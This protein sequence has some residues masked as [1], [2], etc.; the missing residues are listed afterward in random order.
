MMFSFARTL[1]PV[2]MAGAALTLQ[3]PSASAQSAQEGTLSGLTLFPAQGPAAEGK[4]LR[5]VSGSI[6]Q[7]RLEGEHNL[8]SFHV[9]VPKGDALK[10]RGLQ[11]EALSAI[12]ILPDLSALEIYVN[13]RLVGRMPID[14]SGGEALQTF[15]L[16]AGLL[17]EGYNSVTFAARHR[18]RVDC[19]VPATWELWTAVNPAN[20]GFVYTSGYVPG[21]PVPLGELGAL[22]GVMPNAVGAT[23]IALKGPSLTDRA[24]LDRALEVA[25]L[26]AAFGQYANP[27]MRIGTQETDGTGL[28][29]IVGTDDEV[30]KYQPRLQSGRQVFPGIRLF[31][32]PSTGLLQLVVEA[33]NPA[34]LDQ[35]IDNLASRLQD[36]PAVGSPEGLRQFKNQ[37]GYHVSPNERITLADAGVPSINFTGRQMNVEFPLNLPQAMFSGDYSKVR[38][39]VDARTLNPLSFDNRL[40]IFVNGQPVASASLAGEGVDPVDL[41]SIPLGGFSAGRNDVRFEFTTLAESDEACVAAADGNYDRLYFNSSNSSMTFGSFADMRVVPNLSAANMVPPP[42]DNAASTSIQVPAGHPEALEAAADLIV[43]SAA[44][45]Q[46]VKPVSIKRING[47]VGD[48]P[49]LIVAPEGLLSGK[50]KQSVDSIRSLRGARTTSNPSPVIAASTEDGPLTADTILPDAGQTTSSSRPIFSRDSLEDA[51]LRSTGWLD[52]GYDTVTVW[53]RKYGFD[54]GG[55]NLAIVQGD[56]ARADVVFLQRASDLTPEGQWNALLGRPVKQ[57]TWTVVTGNTIEDLKFGVDELLGQQRL[58]WLKGDTSYYNSENGRI[59]SG[60]LQSPTY[61]ADAANPLNWQNTR[62]VVAGM[63]SN[64]PFEFSLFVIVFAIVL[65]SVYL[66]MLKRAGR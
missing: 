38:I 7:L 23:Q 27:D 55:Q 56:P 44:M 15:S 60:R 64:H 36:I 32:H 34:A 50:A 14:A 6:N 25:Q 4:H 3:A 21:Q 52:S 51:Y 20:T 33:D 63:V 53:L 49:G 43:A 59:V 8:K 12:S 17:Q 46:Q 16:P 18:H 30:A 42:A 35:A 26:V 1:V 48:K 61:Y 39:G 2:L 65:G 13:D 24:H 47:F 28:E 19:S 54:I 41:L 10:L 37:F 22:R 66:F 9:Y 31:E 57:E 40:Q 45:S 11:V 29:I 5:R 58:S 62:L